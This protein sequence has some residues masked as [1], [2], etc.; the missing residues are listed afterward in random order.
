MRRSEDFRRT[1]RRGVRIGRPTL[2]L[3]AAYLARGTTPLDPRRAHE[4]TRARASATFPDEVRVGFV[5]GKAVGN[6]VNRNLVRRRLRHLV[7]AQLPG[8]P[9]AVRVVVRALPR[10][11]TAP[12]ELA[13]DLASAWSQAVARL[14]ARAAEPAGVS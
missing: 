7:A 2:V 13:A 3:H 9:A 14:G 12:A 10:A 1:V 5:V 4:S 8:T 6:A 11:A